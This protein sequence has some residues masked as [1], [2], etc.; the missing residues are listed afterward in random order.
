M[1]RAGLRQPRQFLLTMER[2]RVITKKR[3]TMEKNDEM[4]GFFEIMGIEDFKGF[5]SIVT[6]GAIMSLP[7]FVACTIAEW[8]SGLY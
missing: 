1:P 4:N 2:R 8:L 6:I 5:V 7:L 3:T